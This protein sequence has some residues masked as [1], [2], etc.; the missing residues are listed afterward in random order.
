M[1]LNIRG[2]LKRGKSKH[3]WSMEMSAIITKSFFEYCLLQCNRLTENLH[4]KLAEWISINAAR[5]TENKAHRSYEYELAI[6]HMIKSIQTL[7]P[8][9]M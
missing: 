7:Y 5:P 8:K 3:D 6:I 2:Y 9:W 4:D 1:K